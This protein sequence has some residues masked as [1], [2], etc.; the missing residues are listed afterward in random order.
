MR[1]T[2]HINPMWCSSSNYTWNVT[3]C[4]LY[5]YSSSLSAT[6]TRA[7]AISLESNQLKFIL[8]HF[9]SSPD[10]RK[11]IGPKEKKN[12]PKL[13]IILMS[14]NCMCAAS[15]RL[16]RRLLWLKNTQ[17]R[18]LQPFQRNHKKTLRWN[19]SRFATP[20]PAEEAHFSPQS[21]RR[22]SCPLR[23]PLAQALACE[24]VYMLVCVF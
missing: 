22:A 5:I 16:L 9:E 13:K 23:G 14:L 17:L 21:R 8:F 11:M 4:P 15:A 24:C 7:E 19:G 18:K 6:T 12:P 1:E 2:L 20:P 10:V 3:R